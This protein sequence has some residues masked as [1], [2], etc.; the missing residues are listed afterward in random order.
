MT[1]LPFGSR[2]RNL[3]ALL[4][5]AVAMLAVA[6]YLIA[7]VEAQPRPR[8]SYSASPHPMVIGTIE[9]CSPA[10]LRSARVRLAFR[11]GTRHAM[12]VDH[13]RPNRRGRW[14]APIPHGAAR[15]R[16]AMRCEGEVRK[17]TEPI[18]PGHSLKVT[19]ALPGNRASL[20]PVLIP[21]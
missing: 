10:G 11:K 7:P 13:A 12:Q 5:S 1:T 21:Y 20:P 4:L 6:A 16:I 18:H 19:E 2:V 9:A 15:V 14:H 17:L 8:V 3:G